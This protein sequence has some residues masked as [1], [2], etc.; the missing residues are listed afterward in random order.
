MKTRGA[1]H[2]V[3]KDA[4]RWTLKSSYLGN[5]TFANQAAA[6]TAATAAA[7]D[8]IKSGHASEII[9]RNRKRRRTTS[10]MG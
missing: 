2:V 4:R 1:V 7:D 3:S 5:R 10:V 8:A 6:L 9:V